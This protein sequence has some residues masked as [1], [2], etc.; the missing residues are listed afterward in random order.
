MRKKL[1]FSI[2]ILVLFVSFYE[3]MVSGKT[4]TYMGEDGNWLITINAKIE[5]LN[6][7]YRIVV[8]Y[9]GKKEVEN[10]NFNIHPHYESGLPLLNE[11]GY[12]I[13]ECKNECTYNDKESKLLLFIIWKEKNQSVENLDFIDLKK[14][15]N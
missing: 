15:R 11:N 12:Y 7:S 5:G 9:K 1:I 10:L 3:V 14:I 2:I 6:S 13:Y 8:K 4:V